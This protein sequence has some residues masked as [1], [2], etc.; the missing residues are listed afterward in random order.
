MYR[1]AKFVRE[2]TETKAQFYCHPIGEEES[3]SGVYQARI[4]S[5]SAYFVIDSMVGHPAINYCSIFILQMLPATY[6]YILTALKRANASV[7]IRMYAVNQRKAFLPV[8][9]YAESRSAGVC[10]FPLDFLT[11]VMT[12]CL[13]IHFYYQTAQS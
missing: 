13:P 5:L 7:Q 2:A 1:M 12:L 9:I 6:L 10:C 3:F 11:S 8:C 4:A